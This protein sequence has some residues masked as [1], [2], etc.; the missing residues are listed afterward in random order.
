MAKPK[1]GQ[2][3]N[4]S[5]SPSLYTFQPSSLPSTDRHNPHPYLRRTRQQRR[6]LNGSSSSSPS[7]TSSP[8][9]LCPSPAVLSALAL[10]AAAPAVVAG[11]PL[12]LQT[13]PP[14]FLCPF[15][16]RDNIELI[17]ETTAT[18]PPHVGIQS[19]PTPS[20]TTSTSSKPT[21]RRQVADKYVQGPD[22]RWRKTDV[23]TLYGSTCCSSTALPSVD[24]AQGRPSSSSQIPMPTVTLSPAELDASVLPAGWKDQTTTSSTTESTIILALAISLAV[25]IC[26]FMVG[27]IF[28]RKRKKPINKEDLELKI[29]YKVRSD[30]ASEDGE[31]EK[32]V[33][34]KM[35]IWAKATARWKA[36]VR[37]SAR[38]RRKRHISSKPSRSPSP[39]L[40]D[41]QEVSLD[42]P[43]I[44]SSRRS[45]A[46]EE[47]ARP[48]R[49]TLSDNDN[50]PTITEQ[51]PILPNPTT[52]PRASLPPAY[53][54]PVMQRHPRS[55]VPSDS[56]STRSRPGT[57]LF[58]QDS[59]PSNAED[60]PIP[61]VP[62]ST[63]H[64]ATDDKSRLAQIHEMASSP[65]EAE[66]GGSRSAVQEVSAPEWHEVPDEID[67]FDVELGAVPR[68]GPLPFHDFDLPPSFPPLPSKADVPSGYFDGNPFS[69]GEDDISALGADVGPSAPP[70]EASPSAP[71]IS[72]LDL[73]P[74]APSLEDQDNVF[75]DWE[76]RTSY[77]F[78]VPAREDTDSASATSIRPP[79][80]MS[81]SSTSIAS[82]PA[83]RGSASGDGILP[84]Y[85]P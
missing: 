46:S 35:R 29:R 14:S 67:D 77:T 12:P 59:Y 26:V 37:H 64:V 9:T 62:P 74:S 7:R 82:L 72:D 30:D 17:A 61:Y 69:Y 76:S 31:R 41:N 6:R 53:R 39:T 42:I 8:S 40:S 15:I 83:M 54:S 70:F 5:N 85:R 36:N 28:W 27:C 18:I 80:S 81:A 65:P 68:P 78:G 32:E 33:R 84:L 73:E 20:A 4:H 45:L 1:H 13:A 56:N 52:P 51:S 44:V 25:F 11:S 75:Q 49:S 47:A 21:K 23:W 3:N 79:M 10:I 43:S 22:N 24:D 34:G 48:F 16:E 19:S 55:H 50:T 71:P 60:E 38:R 58:E 2:L 57:L 66:T 63:G